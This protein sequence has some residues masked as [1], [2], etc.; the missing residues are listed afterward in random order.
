ML[1]Y[2]SIKNLILIQNIEIFFQNGLCILTGETGAGKSMILDSLSLITGGRTKS[3]I[4]P[5][6]GKKT[7]VT[8][9]IDISNF[10][11][12]KKELNKLDIAVENDLIIKRT[13][14]DD[15]KSKS[16]INDCLV[17]LSTLKQATNGII[18]IHSQFSEQ[19]LLDSSTH[20][21]TLDDYGVNKEDLIQL[22]KLWEQV[23]QIREEYELFSREMTHLAEIKETNE[24]DLKEINVLNPL[25]NE[26]EELEN[27]R[28]L[29]KNYIKISESINNVKENFLGDN[30]NGIEN[31]IAENIKVL[32][33]IHDLLDNEAKKQIKSLESI[34]LEISE[35]SRYF[36]NM[37][38]PGVQ[39]NSLE[40]IEQRVSEFKR[41]ARKHKIKE[42]ELYKL[43]EVIENKLSSSEQFDEKL[44]NIKE[45]MN[46]INNEYFLQSKVISEVRNKK[47]KSLDDSINNEFLD[48][49]LENA[50]FQTFIEKNEFGSKG[51]DKV[52]FKIKT[53]PKA[54]MEE[55]K[56]ISS[57]GELCRIALA[58]KVTADKNKLSTLFFDEVDSGIGGAVSTAVGERLKRLGK[59]RQVCVIT[60]SPQV[61][62]LANN[63]LK[64][65]KN[66]FETKLIK[67]DYTERTEE[68]ARML[69][70]KEI[71]QEAM[72]AAKKLLE[73]SKEI[74]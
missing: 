61:A 52:T 62:S 43:P 11:D 19:G 56:K 36:S 54:E 68:I 7:I 6:K 47:S 23:K 74:S 65:I 37:M 70:A 21:N 53:N 50:R 18:E 49:K 34:S 4:K 32:N 24:N 15:G 41:I 14:S 45:R 60:H 58:I 69:S 38:D 12:I 1:K 2:L 66:Q 10:Q 3:S 67:L 44:N 17:S 40:A 33:G 8:A 46:T 57:G 16:F 63:H 64:V 29:L 28:R 59:N 30:R 9:Q 31:L 48:L 13:I 51:Q 39:E 5:E 20:I 55:I 72:D 42:N 26:F 25:L 35:I 71:T 73:Q 22:R 27:K